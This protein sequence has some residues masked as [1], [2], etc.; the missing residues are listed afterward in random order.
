VT[1]AIFD[2]DNTL[3]DRA[4]AFH[5]WATDLVQRLGLD[6]RELDWL[7]ESDGDG[8]SSRSGF[9]AQVKDRYGLDGPVEEV[10]RGV[11]AGVLDRVEPYPGAIAALD[12]LRRDGWLIALAT[13][14]G[15]ETQWAKIRRLGLEAHVD[16]IA[17]SEEVGAHKPDRLMFETAAARCGASL[18]TTDWMVGDCPTRDIGGAHALGLRTVWMRRGRDWQPSVP[19]PTAVADTVSEAAGL[20]TTEA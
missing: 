10:L 4:A 16:A 19:S 1:L 11:R 5:G 6:P 12:Q 13:N 3:I 17:V 7:I 15:T 18:A 20:L 2:M 14:G 9:A 8:F